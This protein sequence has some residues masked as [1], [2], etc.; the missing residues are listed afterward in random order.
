LDCGWREEQLDPPKRLHLL[1]PKGLNRSVLIVSW[2]K[3]FQI[4]QRRPPPTELVE[5]AP[6]EAHDGIHIGGPFWE[7]QMCIAHHLVSTQL[8]Q[9]Q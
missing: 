3:Q 5:Y 6:T 9:F 7:L 4:I 8:A 2:T 1:K